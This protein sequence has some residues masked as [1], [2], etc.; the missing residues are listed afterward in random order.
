MSGNNVTPYYY[1]FE[2]GKAVQII[3]NDCFS[4][5]KGETIVITADTQTDPRVVNAMAQASFSA[6]AKPMIIWMATP[7][8][9]GGMVDDFLPVG[10]PQRCTYGGR[11]L[12][13]V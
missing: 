6:G 2:L 3:V 1:E 7:P 12:D 13:R 5:K 9:P 4:L 11:L 8:G 10:V